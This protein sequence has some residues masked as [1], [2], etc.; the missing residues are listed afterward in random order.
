[1]HV[2]HPPLYIRYHSNVEAIKKFYDDIKVTVDGAGPASGCPLIP[3]ST[4]VLT[5]SFFCFSFI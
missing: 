4:I 5:H 1:M 2:V 3:A